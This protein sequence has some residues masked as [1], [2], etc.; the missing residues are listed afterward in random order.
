MTIDNGAWALLSEEEH[1]L[2]KTHRVS[3]NPD[4]FKKLESL[5]IIITQSNQAKVVGDYQARF[6]HICNGTSL[7]IAAITS[8]CNQR[9]LYCYVNPKPI[10]SKGF[11]MDKDTAKRVV[12]FMFQSPSKAITIEF[13]GGEPLLNFPIIQYIID[14]SKKLNKNTRRILSTPLSPT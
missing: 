4:L 9:C 1:E 11:D 6:S 2:L 13:Q 8:R 5:G 7:H 14:Y 10:S 3:E 12:E